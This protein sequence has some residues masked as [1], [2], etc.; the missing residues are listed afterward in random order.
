MVD[1]RDYISEEYYPQFRHFKNWCIKNLNTHDGAESIYHDVLEKILKR[2]KT[3]DSESKAKGYLWVCLRN[4]VYDT[5]KE[6]KKYKKTEIKEDRVYDDSG[7]YFVP[8]HTEP[9]LDELERSENAANLFN[10]ILSDYPF[11]SN[12]EIIVFKSFSHKSKWLSYL[13]K[14]GFIEYEKI[15]SVKNLRYNLFERIKKFYSNNKFLH[16]ELKKILD[17]YP[18]SDFQVNL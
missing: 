1:F 16:N 12:M 6:L 7:D 18:T 4:A 15:N 5:N 14:Q 2:D 17:Y 8:T 9:D 13:H 11:E 10:F 3:F